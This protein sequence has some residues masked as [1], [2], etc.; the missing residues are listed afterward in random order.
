MRRVGLIGMV[1]LIA[2]EPALAAE[3]SVH[4]PDGNL[5]AAVYEA[6]KKDVPDGEMVPQEILEGV[7]FLD[8]QKRD[9]ADLTGIE[10][11]INLGEARFSHN[12]INDVSPL[13]RCSNLQ[14]LDLA[15]NQIVD[16]SP[17]GAIVKL[18]YLKIEHNQVES[19]EGL[20]TLKALNCL[21]AAHNRIESIAPV[22]GLKKL[23]TLDV[24]HNRIR[25]ISPVASLP[26]LDSLGLAHNQIED[27]SKLPPGRS[28][29]STYLHGNQIRDIS[30]LV[31][32][33]EHDAG[34]PKRF[35]SFWRLYLADNPLDEKSKKMHLATLRELGVKLNME[36]DR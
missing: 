19:L 3:E 2:A 28:M 12:S 21:Y 18:Q 31:A 30:P 13:A 36:Y 7:Y 26:R 23:W 10:H 4:V 27:V 11:C 24:S 8:A 34:G 25:D 9:I 17:L 5:R 35:A 14:S 16:V 6:R 22:A 29:Y 32:L 1:L 20:E 15:H 33:A